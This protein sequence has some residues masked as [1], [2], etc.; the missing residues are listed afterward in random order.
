MPSRNKK[1]IQADLPVS[2]KDEVEFRFV[3]SIEEALE[4]VWGS[5]IWARGSGG[6]GYRIEARL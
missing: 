2:I 4:V 1:D 5:E 3:G 6:K